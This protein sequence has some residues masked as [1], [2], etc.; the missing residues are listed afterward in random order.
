[1]AALKH[2]KAL[3]PFY[4]RAER[5]NRKAGEEFDV[6][7]KRL[8]ELNACG[9]EQGGKPLVEEVAEAPAKAPRKTARKG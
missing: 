5:V 6:T 7:A 1:M 9:V 8:A 3:V 4:D 2:V